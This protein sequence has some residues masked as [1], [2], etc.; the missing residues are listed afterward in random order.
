MSLRAVRLSREG[1]AWVAETLD[2]T[3]GLA[4]P[5]ASLDLEAG[6]AAALVSSEVPVGK[7]H[8]L[9]RGGAIRRDGDGDEAFRRLV[10]VASTYLAGGPDRIAVVVHQLERVAGP[11]AAEW[12]GLVAEDKIPYFGARDRAHY[13]LAGPRPEAAVRKLLRSG[14]LFTVGF[15]ARNAALVGAAPSREVPPDLDPAV[16]LDHLFVDC[17]DGES[18]LLWT[19]PGL[20][21]PG[22]FRIDGRW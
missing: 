16:G 20:A 7:P 14:K 15:L 11:F 1:L 3:G 17:H 10:A 13:W 21:V 19:R 5:L 9:S 8:P 6:E 2:A 18:W 22:G 4:E 12:E